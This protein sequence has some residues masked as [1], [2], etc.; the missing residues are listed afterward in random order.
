MVFLHNF[1]TNLE[2]HLCSKYKFVFF[3]Q[4]PC[5][6]QEHTVSNGIDKRRHPDLDIFI[7]FRTFNSLVEHNSEG[8]H[9]YN[10]DKH[11]KAN[12]M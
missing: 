10:S 5:G 12:E 9:T 6:V 11:I 8:L 3:K 2:S 4:A 7:S 1:P